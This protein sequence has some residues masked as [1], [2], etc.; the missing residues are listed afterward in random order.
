M[1]RASKA[2][3]LQKQAVP[4]RHARQET[5]SREVVAGAAHRLRHVDAI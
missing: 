1:I 3:M 5:F 4:G 2:L